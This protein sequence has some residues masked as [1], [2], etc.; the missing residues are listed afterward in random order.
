[1]SIALVLSGGGARGAYEVG[2]VAGIV[3]VLGLRPSDPAPFQLFTGTSVGAINAA[4]LAAHADRGDMEIEGLVESWTTLS[5]EKHVKLDVLRLMGVRDIGWIRKLRRDTSTFGRSFLDPSPLFEVVNRGV[6]WDRLH[7]NVRTGKTQGLVVTALHIASGRTHMFAE[8]APGR[9]FQ[10]SPDPRRIAIDGPITREHV[11]A[12]AA[13]PLVFPAHRIEGAYYCDGGLR[14]NTPL[15][16]ALRSGA[17]KLVVIRLLRGTPGDLPSR[18]ELYPNPFFLTGKLLAALLLDPIDYDLKILERT[19]ALME[20][21]EET[22]DAD[23]LNRCHEVL[24]KQRGV[25]YRRVE[26][27]AFRPSADLGVLAG[28]FLA[29]QDRVRASPLTEFIVRRAAMLSETHEADLVSFLLFDGGFA[30]RLVEAGRRDARARAADIRAF[31]AT[32]R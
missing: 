31:F 25:S 4:Y 22:L 32:T 12:S 23:E 15:S 30:E 26:A 7:E 18:E 6:K 20:T 21:L 17:D 2:V 1:M 11:F 19:N 24:E 28:D 14:F 5:L 16:P 3:D 10:P 27:L 8:L 13:I 9:V 29:E